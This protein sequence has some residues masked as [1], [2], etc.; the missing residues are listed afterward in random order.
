MVNEIEWILN[1]REM[2][3]VHKKK[4]TISCTEITVFTIMQWTTYKSLKH[5]VGVGE[6]TEVF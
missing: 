5:F 4:C 1:R 3:N 6:K 2:L